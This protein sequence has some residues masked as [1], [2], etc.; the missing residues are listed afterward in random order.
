MLARLGWIDAGAGELSSVS[1]RAW[2]EREIRDPMARNLFYA[3]IRTGT[4]TQALDL[5][6]IGPALRQIQRTFRKNAVLYVQGGW[7][8]IVEQ[9][10]EIAVRAGATLM[11]STG[12][13]AIK[14]D[15]E[16]RRLRLSNGEVMEVG[17]VISAVPLAETC[18]LIRDADRTSLRVWQDQARP[19]SVACLDL[20]LKRLPAPRR[21]LV[22]GIDEPVFFTNQSKVVP[23]LAENGSWVMHVL[24]YNGVGEID[25]QKD[26]ALLERIMDLI[27]PAGGKKSS[28]GSFC[29]I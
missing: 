8:S 14:H 7:Q 2:I 15:G 17:R 23:S 22:L 9:L 25:P 20:C 3:L 28:P 29:R 10:R 26:E 16:V 11:H 18:R 5:H 6:S 24:K 4:F 21:N 19:V 27:Q 12:V 13:A 1:V